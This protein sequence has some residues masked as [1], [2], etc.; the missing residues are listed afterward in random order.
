MFCI[1]HWARCLSPCGRSDNVVTAAVTVS[2]SVSVS[3]KVREASQCSPVCLTLTPH[4]RS[5][6][7]TLTPHCRSIW[8]TL[9]LTPLNTAGSIARLYFLILIY[10]QESLQVSQGTEAVRSM[11]LLSWDVLT[12]SLCCVCVHCSK[13]HP[14]PVPWSAVYCFHPSVWSS[15]YVCMLYTVWWNDVY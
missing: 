4:C 6:W 12:V 14:L 5:V 1:V 15:S 9:T 7:L 11:M 3:V 8:L 10:L 13:F 2:V